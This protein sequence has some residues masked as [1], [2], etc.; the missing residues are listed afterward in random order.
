VYE[1]RA[2]LDVPQELK[3]QAFTLRGPWDQAW[4]VGDGEDGAARL[5]DPEV[6][7]QGRERVVGD[8]RPGRGD[9]R[10]QARLTGARKTDEG[11]IGDALEL[12][13]DVAGL[14]GL[15]EQRKAGGLALDR[16]EAGVAQAAATPAG[17]HVPAA[18]TDQVGELFAVRPEDHRAV[19]DR[20]DQGVAGRSVT[21]VAL[22]GLAA[23][24]LLMRVEVIV[25]QRCRVV[26]HDQHDV[27]AVATVGAV[28]A[29]ERLELLPTDAGAAVPAVTGGDVQHDTVDERGHAGVLSTHGRRVRQAGPPCRAAALVSR[30]ARC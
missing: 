24:G 4:H 9:R 8:L 6:G 10:Y 30:P 25:Q 3:A 12:Q 5:D 1:D 29:A 22:A 2:A 11:D 26:L 16:R 13:D 23:G 14:T 28:R 15:A 17:H 20:K 19:R 18:L 27:T 21:K 7:H